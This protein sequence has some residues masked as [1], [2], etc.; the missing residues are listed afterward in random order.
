MS[1]QSRAGD[2]RLSTLLAGLTHLTHDKLIDP[3]R[4][5]AC[6]RAGERSLAQL[7]DRMLRD[8][9]LTRAQAHAAAYGLLKLGRHSPADST[10]A[11]PS[12]GRLRRPPSALPEARR[13]PAG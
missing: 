5:R 12:G 1:N 9:G 2:N 13:S 10:R 11:S 3:L 6:S 4:R 8:I 7:D